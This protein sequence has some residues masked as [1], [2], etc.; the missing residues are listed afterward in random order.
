MATQILLY[1]MY[2]AVSQLSPSLL[3]D[4][5]VARVALELLEHAGAAD[6]MERAAFIV[7]TP[8]GALELTYWPSRGVYAATW[9]GPMPRNVVGVIH[10]HPKLR[11]LPSAQD[12][13][14]ASRLG[15]PFYVVSRGALCVAHAGRVHCADRIPWLIRGG[16]GNVAMHWT[17]RVTATS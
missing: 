10:T 14:E 2:L 1:V 12:R 5:P 16:M 8:A 13:A 17:E 7:R 6:D 3:P 11:P 4:G 9:R 15:L